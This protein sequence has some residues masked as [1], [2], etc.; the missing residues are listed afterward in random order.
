M[1]GISVA[2][3]MEAMPMV[4]WDLTVRWYAYYCLEQEEAAISVIHGALES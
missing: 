4:S 1:F 3:P 2:S